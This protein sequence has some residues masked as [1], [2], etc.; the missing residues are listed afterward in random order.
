MAAWSPTDVGGLSRKATDADLNLLEGASSGIV[1]GYSK[2]TGAMRLIPVHVDGLILYVLAAEFWTP[3]ASQSVSMSP[4]LS[5]SES[6]SK[7]ASL[8]PSLSNSPSGSESPSRSASLSPSQSTSQSPS[9]STSESPSLSASESPS[10]S[11]SMS[12]SAS[13]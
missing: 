11:P 3:V 2:P 5:A 4:S 7:S 12:T 13:A 6:P 9:Q 8:S 10:E 1:T